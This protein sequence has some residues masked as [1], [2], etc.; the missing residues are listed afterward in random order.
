MKSE[1]TAELEAYVPGTDELA[2][3][4][5]RVTVLGSGDPC[6][7]PGIKPSACHPVGGSIRL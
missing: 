6:V 5:G 7:R 1:E 4:E 3:D 2:E